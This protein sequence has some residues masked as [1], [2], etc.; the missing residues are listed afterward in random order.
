MASSLNLGLG[1]SKLCRPHA[2]MDVGLGS[3]VGRKGRP[4]KKTTRRIRGLTSVMVDGTL[5]YLGTQ[6]EFRMLGSTVSMVS[7]TC[8]GAF[9]ELKQTTR[10]GVRVNCESLDY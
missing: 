5:Q 1:L 8:I 2:C 3:S 7:T 10:V 4:R 6:P 9:Y